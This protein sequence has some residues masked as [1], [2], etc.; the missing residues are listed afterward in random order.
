MLAI[1][2]PEFEFEE[3]K[4]PEFDWDS[5]TQKEVDE[6]LEKLFEFCDQDESV[7]KRYQKLIPNYANEFLE[8]YLQFDN[9]NLGS[10]GVLDTASI[11]NY[12][13][14]GFEVE[15]DDLEKQNENIGIVEFST[16]NYPF[17]GIERFLM[18]LKAFDLTPVECYNGFVVY[19]FEWLSSF[20]FKHIE[21]PKKTK[22]YLKRFS[23]E[24]NAK[25]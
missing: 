9:D 6:A 14:Y 13:E 19:E 1:R 7:I 16:G 23:S 22:E 3:E 8:K 15:M 18:V 11:L 5:M 24:G 25:Q 2:Q 20:K 21:L 12:L 17:G 10:L 4:P